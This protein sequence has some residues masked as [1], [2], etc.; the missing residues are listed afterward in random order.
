MQWGDLHQHWRPSEKYF[1]DFWQLEFDLQ[2]NLCN[3]HELCDIR[4]IPSA[5]DWEMIKYLHWHRHTF[6][7]HAKLHQYGLEVY[8]CSAHSKL[9]LQSYI[10]KLSNICSNTC[11][12]RHE[13]I[14]TVCW[15]SSVW[16]WGLYV[17]HS[18][19]LLQSWFLWLFMES[20][21]CFDWSTKVSLRWLSAVPARQ[22]TK[23]IV[24][25]Y[26]SS[27]QHAS[28]LCCMHDTAAPPYM[29]LGI[30]STVYTLRMA[31][32]RGVGIGECD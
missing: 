16:A 21:V 11:I 31:F 29:E 17:Y 18:R 15:T 9:W 4:I 7:L 14:Y 32:L 26:C 20:T 2:N 10:E 3:S 28:V 27:E 19:Q 22:C 23:A 13:M 30:I 1:C 6:R 12:N 25:I 24:H 8:M 5:Q